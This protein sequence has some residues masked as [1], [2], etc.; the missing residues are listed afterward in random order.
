M[1]N[2]RALR[3]WAAAAFVLA[4]ASMAQAQDSQ[5]PVPDTDER[6]VE[7]GQRIEQL[8]DRIQELEAEA[9][10]GAAAESPQINGSP[11]P[12][13]EKTPLGH[14]EGI[15][16]E[17]R[18]AH[19]LLTRDEL[20]SDEFPA[21][22]PMFGTNTRMKIG[23]YIKADFVADFDGTLDSTQF[24][25][26]TIPVEGTPEYGG[27]AYVDFFA[28]ETRF[29]LDIRRIIPGAVPLRG[30]IEGDF[31][32]E[33][34]QFRLRH[35]Y[36]T[37]G[38]FIVG[39]TWT[40][41]SFL[42]AI[43]IMFDFA[44]GDALF[45]GRANQV[46]YQMSLNERW[47][48]SVA[49]EEMQFLGIQNENNLPG[50]ATSQWP[51]LAVRANYKYDG[52]LVWLGTSIGQLHWDG[53]ANGPSDSTVQLAFLVAGRHNLG[54]RAFAT[55]HLSYSE[56]AGENIMAFAGTDAN[57]VLDANGNLETFPAFAAVLGFGYDLT[58]TLTTQGSY[59]YGVLDTPDSR[60]PLALERGG[61][62]HLNLTWKPKNN[63]YLS[64][65]IEIMYGKIRAQNRSTGDATRLQLM[66]K[67]TF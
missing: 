7:Q 24:L 38:N 41:L 57:A 54:E 5:S 50:R 58:S 1:N 19:Q 3:P 21:S 36:I 43:P 23:G 13:A 39:Q 37:A 52:G 32:S 6:L 56:G 8:E 60:A 34:N 48:L 47:K 40:T 44:A 30:F 33:G 18:D 35:A 14:L 51:L 46:R 17:V 31:F 45:G 28:K 22:W 4:A 20:A 49:A 64:T 25:M 15:S 59:A 10:R 63:E 11:S 67:F 62:A 26:R 9:M 55:Y 65:G 27:D 66:A 29:N 53:G 61:V 12:D 42:E 2:F 16:G